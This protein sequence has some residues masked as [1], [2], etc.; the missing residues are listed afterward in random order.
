MKE[1]DPL[2]ELYKS[3]LDGSAKAG[4][5]ERLAQWMARYDAVRDEISS[6]ELAEEQNQSLGALKTRFFPPGKSSA[7]KPLHLA[8]RPW[9]IA[10]SLV[11]ITLAALWIVQIQQGPSVEQH[12][13]VYTQNK[14]TAGERKTIRLADGSK[15]F[16]NSASKIRY[17]E[18]FTG[19]TRE[20][21]L[22]GQA[23]FEVSHDKTKPFVVHAGELTVQVLG[24]TF[25][26]RN[27]T[28][29]VD[30][31]VTVAT[32]KVA[33]K[34]NSVKEFWMLTPGQQ[35]A[36]DHTSGKSVKEQVL[37]SEYIG[38]KGGALV[39]K[40]TPLSQISKQLERAYG[41]T[42]HIKT[43]ALENRKLSLRIN[44]ENIGKVIEMLSTAGE[45]KYF[46][47]GRTITLWK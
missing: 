14:T 17:P 16:M 39:F 35:L 30:A 33:V 32:G 19:N 29:D 9:A 6:E 10:A 42:I 7:R 5:K 38:W 21:Y 15:I 25:D 22:E 20:I 28:G 43:P 1:L 47:K 45:F 8:I 2:N 31:A 46:I 3:I 13:I 27:Y 44:G 12:L 11:L 41:V 24:T 37:A 40:N 18:S 36:Y 23:Y 26:V 34:T 4:D